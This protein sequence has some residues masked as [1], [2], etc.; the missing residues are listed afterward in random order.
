MV[1]IDGDCVNLIAWIKDTQ[2]PETAHK[3]IAEGITNFAKNWAA[4]NLS[5]TASIFEIF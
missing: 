2:Y 5:A 1:E 4:V 3:Q